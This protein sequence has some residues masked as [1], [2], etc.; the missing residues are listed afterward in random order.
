MRQ[1]IQQSNQKFQAGTFGTARY[2]KL[3]IAIPKTTKCYDDATNDANVSTNKV[4]SKQTT[5]TNEST[6]IPTPAIPT[7]VVDAA[8]YATRLEETEEA[9]T[10][11][12]WPSRT[13]YGR[14]CRQISKQ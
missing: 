13:E 6:E 7:P 3:G 1:R 12:I 14:Q 10:R 11:R 5:A 4:H 9:Q 2:D 8:T